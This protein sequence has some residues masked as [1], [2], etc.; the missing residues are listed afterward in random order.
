M[1]K[2]KFLSSFKY[3]TPL[4]HFMCEELPWS[5][6]P[7]LQVKENRNWDHQDGGF[8]LDL[9]APLQNSLNF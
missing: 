2:L 4:L 3:T 7:I 6:S 1:F 8:A 5:P 9:G